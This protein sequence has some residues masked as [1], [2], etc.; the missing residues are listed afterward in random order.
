MQIR[1]RFS[2][3]LT[4]CFAATS[5]TTGGLAA[6]SAPASIEG[7]L[8]DAWIGK[9]TDM[10]VKDLWKSLG[11]QDVAAPKLSFSP[12][13]AEFYDLVSSK[14]AL[15]ADAKSK[16][17]RDGLVIVDAGQRKYSMAAAL[18]EIYT[19]DLPL[20]VTTDMVLDAA[21]R[22]F[23][24][25]LMELEENV[26]LPAVKEALMQ[27]R[28]EVVKISKADPT[29]IEV[30]TDLDIYLSVALNL[31]ETEPEKKRIMLAPLLVGPAPILEILAKVASLKL[32]NP[33]AYGDAATTLYGAER[34]VDW[35][36]FKPRGHYDKTVALRRYFRALMWMGRADTGFE[37]KESR[38]MRAAAL[39][40]YAF[41]S[42]GAAKTMAIVGDVVDL[43]VGQ[44]DNLTPAQLAETMKLE[45]LSKPR[46]LLNMK[47]L[48]QLR[49]ALAASGA[50]N[51]RIRSALVVSNPFTPVK[52][53][54]PA[55]FQLFGQRFVLDSFVLSKVVYDDII[56][57]GEKKNRRMP[58]AADVMAALGND[59][60]IKLLTPELVQWNYAANMATLR[61]VVAAWDD[62]QWEANLY[63]MWLGSLR[64]L[65]QAPT[66]KHVP[67]LMHTDAWAR[68]TLQTQLA[69][70]AQL[71][72]D[73]ILYAKQSY[74]ASMGCIYPKGYVE[75]YPAFY[76]GLERFASVAA[77]RLG[78]L[79]TRPSLAQHYG[80]YFKR[81]AEVMNRLGSMAKKEL[82]GQPFSAADNDFLG[83]TIERRSGGGGYAATPVWTGWYL[84]LV[85][86]PGEKADAIKFEPTI[87]DVH[88]DPDTKR[89]LEVGTGSVNFLVA[90]IDNDGDRAIHVGPTFSYY[91]FTQPAEKRLT[92]DEWTAMLYKPETTPERPSWILPHLVS[93]TLPR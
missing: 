59:F 44:S 39:L 48:A 75:P 22:S 26:L 71:R 77:E 23:D 7:E 6:P 20:L 54:P 63:S 76:A 83:D 13:K 8:F 51:Q 60:A 3:F 89:V 85:Y 33:G 16:L 81:F 40:S 64:A 25:I 62:T 21:H 1:P 73:T 4:I 19:S 58:A 93:S 38:Q 36:Q 11:I 24:A 42:S 57:K 69:S 32:E 80:T 65:N 88:T 61:D 12:A 55:L 37:L 86:T 56:F 74:T 82:A 46:A 72:H 18:Y 15:S 70:W 9:Y 10:T 41:E 66:G 43:M 90:A 28:A 49:D 35:S 14:L 2:G 29:L 84:D 91:E 31:L 67:E 53:A 92:D 87:A 68:K 17:N 78:K 30:A 52:V 50:G 47:K 5:L 34:A 27:A 45:G 79:E